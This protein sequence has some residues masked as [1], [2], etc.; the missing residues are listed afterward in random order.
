MG[1]TSEFEF[2]LNSN[3]GMTNSCGMWYN[4][5][6]TVMQGA[7]RGIINTLPCKTVLDNE[8]AVYGGREEFEV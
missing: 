5:I 4:T 1:N 7:H 2:Y 3:C 8:S 6:R